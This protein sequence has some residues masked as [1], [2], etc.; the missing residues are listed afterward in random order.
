VIAL[1]PFYQRRRRVLSHKLWYAKFNGL[2]LK[3]DVIGTPI[4]DGLPEW[5][6]ELYIGPLK[7]KRAAQWIIDNDFV[8]A[9]EGYAVPNVKEVELAAKRDEEKKR[10]ANSVMAV[11]IP[12]SKIERIMAAA[13]SSPAIKIIER[14][15]MDDVLHSSALAIQVATM[16]G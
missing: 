10:G 9:W 1:S 15:R 11:A 13:R 14:S 12:Q 7:T 16:I 4:D 2:T 8:L 5:N 3:W 6:D